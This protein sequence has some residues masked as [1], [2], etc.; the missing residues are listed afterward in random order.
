MLLLVGFVA[1][2]GR[3]RIELIACGAA[4]TLLGA[5]WYAATALRDDDTLGTGGHELAVAESP[6]DYL[7]RGSRYLVQAVELPGASGRD[8]YLYLVAAALVAA[9]GMLLRQPRVGL[10]AAALTALTV[11]LLPLERLLHTVYFN[12]WQL[13]GY[14]QATEYGIIREPTIASNLQSWYG[15]IGLAMSVVATVV[16]ARAVR[17]RRLPFLALTLAVSPV[18]FVVGMAIVTEYH[19]LNGRFA[20]GGVALAA[21]TWGV[22]RPF[23]AG[24]AALVAISATTVIL[25]LVGFAERP[26]GIGLLEG[27]DRPSVWQ[28]PR[29]WSQSTQPEIA[30]MIARLDERAVAGTTVAVTRNPAIYPF[31]FVGYPGLDHPLCTPTRSP[32]HQR[33]ERHWAVSPLRNGC[34]PV[35]RT[36][37]KSPPWGVYRRARSVRCERQIVSTSG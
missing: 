13:V 27:A 37:Q 33:G 26:A 30:Q 3:A 25:S 2:R 15:P 29:G 23:T 4:G 1:Q 10:V 18:V 28:L 16:V 12:G 11:L 34:V 14:D 36:D 5:T 35:W 21:A 22:V 9:I 6:L 31:A 17:L 8:L 24:A 32:R 7:A 20:M 19:P